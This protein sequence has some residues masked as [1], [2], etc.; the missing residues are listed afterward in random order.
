MKETLHLL[1]IHKHT[2]TMVK[3][4]MHKLSL[5]HPS[6]GNARIKEYTNTK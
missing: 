6:S 4:Q 3:L 1:V 2:K 5:L